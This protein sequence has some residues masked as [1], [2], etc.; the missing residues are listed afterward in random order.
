MKQEKKK[1]SFAEL[2]SRFG[3]FVIL[4]VAVV[5]ASLLSDTFLTTRNIS[6]I[7]RQNSVV[8]IIAFGA[9]MV[10]VAGEVDLSPGSVCAFAGVISTMVMLS[11]GSV[12]LSLIVG[13]LIGAAFGFVNGWVITTAGIPAFIMTL[14]TQ[15]IGRGGVMALTNAQPVSGFDSSFTVMPAL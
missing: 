14:A 11:T 2:Y 7:I 15:F 13:I 6:N 5:V 3:I 9:Q 12:V 4:I 10:L 8:M 1:M